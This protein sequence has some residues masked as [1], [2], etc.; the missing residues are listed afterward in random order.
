MLPEPLSGQF[1]I[2]PPKKTTLS[3]PS[4]TPP[5]LSPKLPNKPNTSM[6]PQ[7][8]Q[9]PSATYATSLAIDKD[10]PKPNH[11][12]TLPD[13][14][15]ETMYGQINKMKSHY[16]TVSTC[17]KTSNMYEQVSF[18]RLKG[19]THEHDS[20]KLSKAL[21]TKPKL[22]YD[23]VSPKSGRPSKMQPCP[24]NPCRKVPDNV[25]KISPS[26]KHVPT[27]ENTYE[28]IPFSPAKGTEA[29]P[30]QKIDKPRRFFFTDKKTKF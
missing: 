6:E 14:P 2:T 28:Q 1:S 16:A 27:M 7:G 20:E 4:S 3:S 8:S 30:S 26:R 21:P 17:D 25:T 18:G 24:E 12:K 5:K 9:L 23:W 13:S 22:S 10:P 29:K 15:R 11:P 19:V